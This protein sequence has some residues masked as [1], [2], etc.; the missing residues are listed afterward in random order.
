[1]VCTFFKSVSV[2]L[3]PPAKLKGREHY[4]LRHGNSRIEAVKTFHVFVP[5][6][7]R[8]FFN[9]LTLFKSALIIYYTTY[10]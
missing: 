4:I 8:L 2:S 9:R 7:Y 5:Q 3:N 10:A 1:M 6:H